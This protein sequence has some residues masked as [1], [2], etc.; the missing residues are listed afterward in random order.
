MSLLKTLTIHTYV[1]CMHRKKATFVPL[2]L[3]KSIKWLFLHNILDAF[4]LSMVY[5]SI[6][7]VVTHI[8]RE[9]FYIVQK[10]TT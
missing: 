3:K 7:P 1:I 4:T 8:H 2:E 5:I 6:L 10:Q 9:Y